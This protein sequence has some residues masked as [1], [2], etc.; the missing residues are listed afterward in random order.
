MLSVVGFS[1]QAIL[2]VLDLFSENESETDC[3]LLFTPAV[4]KFT[5]E[6]TSWVIV[7]LLLFSFWNKFSGFTLKQNQKG[8]CGWKCEVC[9]LAHTCGRDSAGV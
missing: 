4:Y 1:T 5:T 2:P 9:V 8:E 3:K 7:E 6:K